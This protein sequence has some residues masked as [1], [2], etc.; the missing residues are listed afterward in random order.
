MRTLG[1]AIK[2]DLYISSGYRT[3]RPRPVDTRAEVNEIF[4]SFWTH[5]PWSDIFGELVALFGIFFAHHRTILWEA[6]LV[7]YSSGVIPYFVRR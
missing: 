7:R 4:L 2:T 5:R 6:P 1:Q 3:P